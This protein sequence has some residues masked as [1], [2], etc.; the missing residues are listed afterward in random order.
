MYRVLFWSCL[1]LFYL[2]RLVRHDGIIY[3]VCILPA[4]ISSSGASNAVLVSLEMGA[5][6]PRVP[7]DHYTC[8][9][10][11]WY[12]S[13]PFSA[14]SFSTPHCAGCHHCLLPN[15]FPAPTSHQQF[16]FTMASLDDSE[17]L[18]LYGSL[19]HVLLN[20]DMTFD[21]TRTRQCHFVFPSNCSLNNYKPISS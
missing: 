12:M 3:D 19:W 20:T 10:S 14:T 11:L 16:H 6:K 4:V 21:V 8:L 18:S 13:L 17:G 15:L 9:K 2:S 5:S 1:C 7:V